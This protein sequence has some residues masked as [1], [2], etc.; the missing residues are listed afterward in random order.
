MKVMAGV[1][2]I[3]TGGVGS[4]FTVTRGCWQVCSVTYGPFHRFP[5]RPCDIMG[6]L[7]KNE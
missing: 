7:P 6:S 1:I 2:F 5:K 3:W 4:T